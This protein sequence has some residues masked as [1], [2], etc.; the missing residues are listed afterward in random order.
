MTPIQKKALD[1]RYR[2]Q[3]YLSRPASGRGKHEL[4]R[5]QQR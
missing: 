4:N 2:G 3:A 5:T 1:T